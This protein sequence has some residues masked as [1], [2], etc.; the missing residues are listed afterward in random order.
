M[1][2]TR[3]GSAVNAARL[4]YRRE[5]QPAAVLQREEC[6]MSRV[7]VR[8]HACR[9]AA[10]LCVGTFAGVLPVHAQ[11]GPT[12]LGMPSARA[13]SA[14]TSSGAAG[15]V[16]VGRADVETG[17]GGGPETSSAGAAVVISQVYGGGGNSGATYTHDFIELFNRGTAAVNLT[18]WSVQYAS[19]TGT[20]WQRTNLSGTLEPGQYYLIQQ[21]QGAGGTTPLPAPDAS[22]A[23]PMAAGA[24]KVALVNMTTAL[25]GACPTDAMMDFVGF[26]STANCYEGSGPTPAPSNATSARRAGGGCIDTDNNASD[27]T[28]GDPTPRNSGTIAPCGASTPPSGTGTATPSG[29]FT[30]ES[31]LL[32]VA[33]TPAS[34]PAGTGH[35]VTADLSAIGGNAAHA[36]FDD[37]TAGD[38]E[39][40]DGIFSYQI[41]IGAVPPGAKSL[42]ITIRDEQGR[43]GAA[44]IGLTV[45]APGTCAPT[46][47]IADIQGDGPVS[48][49]VG[50]TVTTQG[51][52]YAV[53]SNGFNIQ[54]A[55]GD[56]D[57]ATSDGILVFTGAA[58]PAAAAVG[59]DVCV[60]GTV[61]EFVPGAD[62][63][64]PSLTELTGS[65]T[66][67]PLSPG[68]PLPAPTEITAEMT[69]APDAVARLEALEGMRVTI[70][71][72]TAV[73]PTMGSINEPEATATSNGIF[74]GVVA[75][76]PR[77]F[78]E[79]GVE[80]NDPL[81]PCAAGIDC[82]IPRFDGNPER[83]RVSSA[84]L[85][86]LALD[87]TAGATVTGLVG[88]LDY[89][90]RT[91]TVFA[92]PGASVSNLATFA[93]VPVPLPDELT[94]ASLNVQ[95]FFDT[96]SDPGTSE[97]V[98]TPAAWERRL[99]KASLTIRNVLHSPDILGLVEVE[100][101]ATVEALAMRIN[102]DTIAAGQPDP[103]YTGSLV[104][105]NDIG[106]IDVAFLWKQ[107]R[108]V[109]ATVEQ[110]GKDATYVNPNTGGQE[111]LNDRPPLVLRATVPR[112]TSNEAF[113]LIVIVNHLRS[114]SAL[115]STVPNPSNPANCVLGALCTQGARVRA[116][117]QAQA[118]YLA[119]LV[120][121]LQAAD[122]GARVLLVGDFNAFEA[123]DGYVDVL[124]TVKG[125]PAA[126]EQV[127]VASPD[128]LDPDLVNLQVLLPPAER[129]SYVFDG[130]AQTLDHAL[131]NTAL[132][133][134]VTRFAYGRSNADFPAVL[135]SDGSRP[136]RLS[137]HDGSVAYLGIGAAQLVGRIV[138]D[139]GKAR[140]RVDVEVSNQGGSTAYDV[141]I[142]QL[143]A[144]A[145]GGHGLVTVLTRRPVQL[146]TLA[147]GESRVVTVDLVVPPPVTRFSLTEV[148][149]YTDPGGTLH[150]FSLVQNVVP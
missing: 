110:V 122:P 6:E 15:G 67:V 147:P 56:G 132:F 87:V 115:T 140:T 112:P 52:V 12:A 47:T 123:S 34:N 3:L 13:F 7:S 1:W 138:S 18:G 35:T 149:A 108:V 49:I 131:A 71:T 145:L 113:D 143:S 25:S 14:L 139:P 79:P 70:P 103:G 20:S 24:G 118:E 5:P 28:A 58:P 76:V 77:P 65:L 19:A 59:Y 101:Q 130:N 16:P 39:A 111:V 96:V 133:P 66:I 100:N 88:P 129:Y 135:Y 9:L 21:A 85:G 98:L 51:I 148:G 137:D 8:A 104:E 43:S 45:F 150:N 125:T 127:V 142:N 36:L 93:P 31:V 72:L 144:R 102:A 114:L 94:V 81:L 32:T 74:Y 73:G 41:T 50:Q 116:K 33:V 109:S 119:R 48:P 57:P 84:G 17:G 82:A 4:L 136:E 120:A 95:R 105:G 63:F 128:L 134:W 69:M 146:G 90:F 83:I 80:V 99:A 29:A 106:G 23:I 37:G 61:T 92:E 62:P 44:S 11:V 10:L 117:R 107:S 64:Q 54:M 68:N 86:A 2:R 121:D 97:P 40:G 55:V 60:T 89:G 42:P 91:Y 124:G 22:G 46:H 53:R 126:P 75:G 26:G 78:R 38:V 141:V 30:G 27:F